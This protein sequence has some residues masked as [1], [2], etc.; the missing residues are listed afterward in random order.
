M[1]FTR[2]SQ[3]ALTFY[4]PG[5]VRGAP[6][7]LSTM[8]RQKTTLLGVS[9]FPLLLA[10]ACSSSDSDSGDAVCQVREDCLATET[11]SEGICIAI[12]AETGGA[13][14]TGG[15]SNGA[16]GLGSGGAQIT[17]GT[18][19]GGGTA[20][21]GGTSSGGSP[22]AGGMPA[23]GGMSNSGGTPN[24][25]GL[26]SAGGAPS[27]GGSDAGGA[28][29][30]GNAGLGP[31]GGSAG[32][33]TTG[34]ASS[35]GAEATGG[36]A[37]NLSTG[38]SSGT[39]ITTEGRDMGD[40]EC[41]PLCVDAG[42]D[43]DGDGWGWEEQA[44]CLVV[45]SS[46][47]NSGVSCSIQQVLI[48]PVGGGECQAPVNPNASVQA[49]NL[50]CYLYEI[51]GNHVLSGQQETSW[52]SDPA[53]DV[54]WVHSTVGEYPAVLGGDYL[55]P[56]GTTDRAIAWANAGGITMIRYHMG[57]PPMEDTYENS[58]QAVS[59]GISSVLTVGTAEHTS[60]LQKLDYAAAELQRLEDANVPVLW[61]PFHEA[62]GDWFWWG[63]EGGAYVTQLW[64][65]TYDYLT[66][67]KGLDNL[68]WLFPFAG[69]IN[70]V[71]YPGKAT[72]DLAGPD[73]YD[74]N[75]PFASM[76]NRATELL[77]PGLPIPL[78]ETGQVVDPNIMFDQ[79]TAPWVLFNVW[80]TYQ[81]DGSHNTVQG[82]QTAYSS[83]FTINR[84]D[85]PSFD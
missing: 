21:T 73:T 29:A 50:L 19:S 30:A 23:T 77:G 59:N 82:I 4:P 8:R 46:P 48:R 66:N 58:Q 63:M 38:G 42:S 65:F 33:S 74:T 62:S 78:H 5:P 45:G 35:G 79:Q 9:L 10:A 51:Y 26:T 76:F 11:C 71:V 64:N 32:A 84:D 25:G 6:T 60:F 72:V 13:T 28:S 36:A 31:S 24:A 1:W 81:N 69:A 15:S 52:A 43:P 2:P 17:G 27:T 67:T 3:R 41:Q 49:R 61:A 55:Y 16:G 54:D 39:V 40:G 57:A 44:S 18:N 14:S 53:A 75:Q 20:V 12:A 47:Y 85:L 7:V 34:G 83:P 70:E 80:A 37:G 22:A 56:S 68:I